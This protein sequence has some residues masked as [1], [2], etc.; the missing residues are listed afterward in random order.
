MA[1]Q[2]QDLTPQE[3]SKGM[4]E[5][6]F[7]LVDVR[8]ATQFLPPGSERM[9]FMVMCYGFLKNA[10]GREAAAEWLK[11]QIPAGQM[12]PLSMKA[13]YPSYLGIEKSKGSLTGTNGNQILFASA[14]VAWR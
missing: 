5:G 11:G 1:D 2:V 14:G 6:R 13:L 12:N 3:V 7:L 4:E 9:D 10:R 8:V